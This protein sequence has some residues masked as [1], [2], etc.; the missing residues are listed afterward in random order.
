MAAVN[1]QPPFKVGLELDAPPTITGNCSPTRVHFTGRI[2]G[3]GPGEA[4]FEWVR[5]D[6]AA[7]Q[8]HTLRFTK[9]GPLPVT[10][11]WMLRK[12][13]SGWVALRVLSPIQIES[14]KVEFQ[15]NCGR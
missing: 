15:V 5:S 7:S 8:P 4:T 11:D 2:N 14:R 6:H 13:Y 3:T 1:G 10:Y 12:G 9:A